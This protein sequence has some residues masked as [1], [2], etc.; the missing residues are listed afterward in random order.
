MENLIR[1]IIELDKQ[2][3]LELEA[4]ENEKSKIG[5]F[6]REK[7]QEIESK[8]RKEANDIYAKKKAEM[9]KQISE[10]EDKAQSKYHISMK[11]IEMVFDKH[12]DEWVNDL[13]E[14][15]VNFDMKDEL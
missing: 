4:L 10:A 2:K 7:R 8:Y 1:D 6:I 13:Y 9:D 11:E 15:C 14:Y 5:S 12:H 3:R